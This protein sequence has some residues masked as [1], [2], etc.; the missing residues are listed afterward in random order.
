MT[1]TPLLLYNFVTY[2]SLTFCGTGGSNIH[3][4]LGSL[5]Y[6]MWLEIR[7][8]T[9][10]SCW[11]KYVSRE[12]G[13]E[14]QCPYAGL[15]H[16]IYFIYIVSL[17]C[18]LCGWDYNFLAEWKDS[19]NEKRQDQV[20]SKMKKENADQRILFLSWPHSYQGWSCAKK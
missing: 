2:I 19:S 5:A 15:N 3:N 14:G 4:N 16:R 20:W 1:K 9:L 18:I 6:G 17:L 12:E 8:G 10:K 11:N 13:S 7:L